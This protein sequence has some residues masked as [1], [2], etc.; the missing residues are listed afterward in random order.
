LKYIR[1]R[2]PAHQ[3]CRFYLK[4]GR[5]RFGPRCLRK[6]DPAKLPGHLK[7][8]L[9]RSRPKSAFTVNN[10]PRPSKP[11]TSTIPQ[12]RT[13]SDFKLVLNR[14]QSQ[15]APTIKRSL[16]H[17][18]IVNK[19]LRW[20]RKT[21]GQKSVD[22][23]FYI[24]R[25]ACRFGTA[26][27]RRHDP[28]KVAVCTQFVQGNCTKD[29]C[30][31]QHKIVKDKMP[32]CLYFLSGRCSKDTCPYLH[33]NTGLDVPVCTQF[34]KGHC[35]K[36]A[37]CEHRH[38]FH[39]ERFFE[40]GKCEVEGCAL[41]HVRGQRRPRNIED[42]DIDADRPYFAGDDFIPVRDEAVRRNQISLEDILAEFGEDMAELL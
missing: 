24:K 31:F 41:K 26:C 20:K 16:A 29:D 25:G 4:S 17:K 37:Q 12:P 15:K 38:T 9:A 34:V 6:H 11:S 7:K 27:R 1:K 21:E 13:A 10:N 28:D 22:C 8:K 32:L 14:Q 39:C 36:G 19:A 5:C 42:E 18:K 30:L 23:M 35:D 40:S 3:D 33:V 2:D